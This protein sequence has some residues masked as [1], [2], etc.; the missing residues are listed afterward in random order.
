[1]TNP[2]T[3][4][5]DY[6][7]F[8]V[9]ILLFLNSAYRWIKARGKSEYL[10]HSFLVTAGLVLVQLKALLHLSRT[11]A[12][13]ANVLVFA[14]FVGAIWYGSGITARRGVNGA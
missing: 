9:A 7:L 8:G 6:T 5:L 13:S 2:Q 14:W 1:M 4:F 10:V 12:W 3:P 11:G